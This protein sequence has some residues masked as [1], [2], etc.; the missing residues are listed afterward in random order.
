MHVYCDSELEVASTGEVTDMF[1]TD[2]GPNGAHSVLRVPDPDSGGNASP[3]DG[4]R[5]PPSLANQYPRL[6][7]MFDS[8]EHQI[9]AN[10]ASLQAFEAGA[11]AHAIARPD[12][13]QRLLGEYSLLQVLGQGSYGI[14]FECRSASTSLGEEAGPSLAV[15]LIDK[16]EAAP[17]DIE[18]E[19]CMQQRLN[20]PSILKVHRVIEER[21]FTCIVM[22]L[23]RGG[24]LM[25]VIEAH[26][27]SKT[28]ISSRKIS[29]IA[30]QMMEGIV[31]IHSKLVV[32]RDVKPENFVVDRNSIMDQNC[33][34]AL[35]DFGFACECK[36]GDR[37]RRQCGTKVYWAPEM[38][39]R[40]YAQKVDLW[41]L[42]VTFYGMVNGSVPF[43]NE[44]EV[45][46]KDLQVHPM[47]QPSFV[48]FLKQLLSKRELQRP[49]AAQVLKHDWIL[50][51]QQPGAKEEEPT[52]DW[53]MADKQWD[54]SL[55]GLRAGEDQPVTT[56]TERR[57]D[58]I[59]RLR[60][61]DD[62]HGMAREVSQTS[63]GSTI[64][65][66][67]QQVLH[68]Q[69]FV[70]L[71]KRAD[72]MRTFNWW[73]P[74]KVEDEGILVVDAQSKPTDISLA[75]AATQIIAQM[76]EEHGVNTNMFGSRGAKSLDSFAEEVDSGVCQLMLD[77][78]QH[79]SLVRVVDLVLL[80]LHMKS[81]N[82]TTRMV[83]VVTADVQQD[84][85]MRED[86]NRLPGAKKEPHENL[87][88]VTER[89][90]KEMPDMSDCRVTLDFSRREVFEAEEV[91]SSYPGIRTVYRK[92]IVSG[93]VKQKDPMMGRSWTFRSFKT[94][95][96]TKFF[97][98]FSEEECAAKGIE[99]RA[100]ESGADFSSLVPA[101]IGLTVDALGKYLKANNIDPRMFGENYAQA[102]R[103]LSIELVTGESS[104]MISGQRV[105]RIV[106]VVL[107][108]ITKPGTNDLLVVASEASLS[109]IKNEIVV[110]NRL[111]GTKRR[112]DENH[113]L[114]AKRILERQLKI[115]ENSVNLDGKNVQI[116]EEAKDSK[117]YKGL[118]T[119]YRKRIISAE[120]V[121]PTV[122]ATISD[123]VGS[124]ASSSPN[125]FLGVGATFS[126]KSI[127]SMPKDPAAPV[128]EED[129][130]ESEIEDSA[131]VVAVAHKSSRSIK[132]SFGLPLRL[133][134]S[135]S[136]LGASEKQN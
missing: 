35:A 93:T 24:D 57:L 87:R 15:K 12:L 64:E 55:Q 34:I 114:A 20:H 121:P 71:D 82:D 45:R 98:W 30:R 9:G 81:G 68:K 120:I 44:G 63:D 112:P 78:A 74:E 43:N 66:T 116:I 122:S 47:A 50:G 86:L 97:A 101:P 110:Q 42:G 56:L 108:K 115:N 134:K 76:L 130:R 94:D 117:T 92:E 10:T 113:F 79:K 54:V 70:V 27:R 32:H 19:I 126:Q 132:N 1:A 107:L 23:Y 77:A 31:H 36:A 105:V 89:I 96:S 40:N 5:Q 22:D 75:P 11:D 62:S 83:L 18:Q 13:S 16:A 51:K 95:R 3:A 102:L 111:P 8:Q 127:R 41:A 128:I 38:W 59:R 103:E 29:H 21:C 131:P 37:L 91:S 133:M 69:T 136:R 61:A 6:R 85:R 124:G 7:D 49:S 46:S 65:Q 17:E 53:D 99:L 48:H 60:T 104:L 14:V 4:R 100:P 118:H 52:M 72:K 58:L 25:Q 28:R 26:A 67:P 84:G 123:F 119:V 88:N 73:P 90:L 2:S 125:D 135:R 109:G 39:D 106:D 33:R 129:A 80:R